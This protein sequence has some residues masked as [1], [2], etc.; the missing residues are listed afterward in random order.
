MNLQWHKVLVQ[1]IALL[2]CSAA[3]SSCTTTSTVQPAS[4]PGDGKASSLGAT[5]RQFRS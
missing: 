1:C 5:G 2:T 4:A 3:L